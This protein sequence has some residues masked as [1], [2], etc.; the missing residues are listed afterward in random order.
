MKSTVFIKFLLLSGSL[1]FIMNLKAQENK[2]K[3]KITAYTFG[4]YYY[5]I[6]ADTGF[7]KLKDVANPR[8]Q[9]MNGFKI[10]RI[11]FTYDYD[12]SEKFVARF[13]LEA[14]EAAL[15]S[16]GKTGVFVKD[17]YL[18][19]K[20]IFKGSDF[21]F[22]IQPTPAY[23]I[24]ESVWGNRFLEKTIMD[25]RGIVSSRDLAVSLKGKITEKFGLK[26]CLMFGNGS[27]NSPEN[28][29]YKR[30][31]AHLSLSPINNLTITIYS[32][33]RFRPEIKDPADTIAPVG[34]LPNNA[35]TSGI[36]IGFKEKDKYMIGGE[37]FIVNLDNGVVSGMSVR[38]K[39]TFGYSVFAQ[40][41][42]NPKF[43]LV[44]RFDGFDPDQDV[45]A[46]GDSRTFS[47]FGIS[48]KLNDKVIISPNV[49]YETYEA[50]TGW[51]IKPSLTGRF[52]VFYNF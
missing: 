15:T 22:G 20:D 6:L 42:F 28:D 47:I 12:I 48:Y 46:T 29:K 31:Y 52:T 21:T 5:K 1:L 33:I 50:K 14:D 51:E 7:A 25:L 4:D 27:G 32:D 24:S 34:T 8:E 37:A 45:S 17:A 23:D 26:Y 13:R 2:P 10:R 16:N 35:Q 44:A 41:W 43:S 19:W 38:D 30:L 11:Y 36:F 9:G 3:G 39:I 49:V 40:Y 18:T